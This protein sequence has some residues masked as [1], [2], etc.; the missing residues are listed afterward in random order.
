MGSV[1]AVFGVFA[2]LGVGMSK[3][4]ISFLRDSRT[5]GLVTLLGT[6]VVMRLVLLALLV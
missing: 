3:G 6:G 1:G 2:L 4:L 5:V